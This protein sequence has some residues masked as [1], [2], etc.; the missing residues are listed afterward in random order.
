MAGWTSKDLPAKGLLYK[1]V[2]SVC[3]PDGSSM[4]GS[5]SSSG[6]PG[7]KKKDG[8]DVWFRCFGETG[9]QSSLIPALDACLGIATDAGAQGDAL[10]PY[11]LQM[12]KY[13]PV[14]H[15]NFVAKLEAGSQV[16]R[17]AA[18]SASSRLAVGYNAAVQAL[19]RFRGLHMS[20]AHDF[21]RKC[22]KSHASTIWLRA[23]P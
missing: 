13:M 10:V 8:G 22:C 4:G 12:R 23:G 14:Q 2:G 6:E 20:L 15:A 7:G 5:S 1:D 3:S 21:I 9:A 18:A 17:V 11:L 16:R 19:H